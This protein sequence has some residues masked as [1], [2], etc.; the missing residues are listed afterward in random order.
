MSRC[1]ATTAS[2]R[3]CRC[4]ASASASA[5]A[6][7]SLCATHTRNPTTTTYASHRPPSDAAIDADIRA[8]F[9]GD[10]TKGFAKFWMRYYDT[11]RDSYNVGPSDMAAEYREYRQIGRRAFD[12]HYSAARR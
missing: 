5:S 1:S 9:A 10:T 7:T 2:G 11:F 4:S 8:S 3:R 6:A 12:A